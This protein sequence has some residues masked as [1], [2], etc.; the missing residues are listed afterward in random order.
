MDGHGA[1]E[2]S[3]RPQ[4]EGQKPREYSK[5]ERAEDAARLQAFWEER[6]RCHVHFQDHP[7][8]C[9]RSAMRM[10]AGSG[11]LSFGTQ[12]HVSC[13]RKLQVKGHFLWMHSFEREGLHEEDSAD[14]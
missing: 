8:E 9:G 4:A 14:R 5:T 1:L 10:I 2:R 7:G 6:R 11:S 3:G 13:W 12:T